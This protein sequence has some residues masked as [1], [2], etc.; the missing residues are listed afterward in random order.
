MY[1]ENPEGCLQAI[2]EDLLGRKK[3][4]KHAIPDEPE[5]EMEFDPINATS[6]S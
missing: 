6:E 5:K 3:S 2:L 1:M 4:T